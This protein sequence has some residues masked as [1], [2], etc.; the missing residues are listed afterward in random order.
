MFEVFYCTAQFVIV[1]HAKLEYSV[2]RRIDLIGIMDMHHAQGFFIGE[3]RY[4]SPTQCL[5]S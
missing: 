3:R 5:C 2:G 1:E 4:A